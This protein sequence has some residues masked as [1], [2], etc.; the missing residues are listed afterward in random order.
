M[1]A[2]VLPNDPIEQPHDAPIE[3]SP[4]VVVVPDRA[5]APISEITE[6]FFR[7]LLLKVPL[8]RIEELHLF[9]PLRQGGVETGIAVIAAREE[10]VV[11]AAPVAPALEIP[12]ESVSVEVTNAEPAAADAVD[13]A[14]AMDDVNGDDADDADD[15]EDVNAVEAGATEVVA[16]DEAEAIVDD[17]SPYAAEETETVDAPSAEDASVEATRSDDAV[18]QDAVVAP[19]PLEPIIRHTV[20]TARYRLVQK[21]PERGKWEAD[22]VAEAEAPLITV[23]TVVRGV[24][25]RAGEESDTTRFSAAQIARALRLQLGAA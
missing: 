4:S 17:E 15:V 24:L 18:E 9:S 8:D 7:A 2:S 12:F 13:A 16:A 3:E 20:Y 11:E 6:R 1:S 21:G 25:R 14:D 5:D 22:V 19:T 23:E 10:I